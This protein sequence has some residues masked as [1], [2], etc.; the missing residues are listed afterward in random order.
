MAELRALR[1]E[2]HDHRREVKSDNVLMATEISDLQAWRNK[3]LGAL[4][5]VGALSGIVGGALVKLVGLAGAG[6][7]RAAQ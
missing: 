5:F 3:Q 7:G 2:L 1:A 4:A 6:A